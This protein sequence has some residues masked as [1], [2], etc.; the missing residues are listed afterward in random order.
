MAFVS[1][2]SQTYTYLNDI[3]LQ[4]QGQSLSLGLLLGLSFHT[5]PRSPVCVWGRGVARRPTS[6]RVRDR[7]PR[8]V[9]VSRASVRVL[10]LRVGVVGGLNP[11]TLIHSHD[12]SHDAPSPICDHFHQPKELQIYVW[13]YYPLVWYL[14]TRASHT[15]PF[16]TKKRFVLNKLLSQA[17][18][19]KRGP[20][21]TSLRHS[22]VPERRPGP[23]CDSDGEGERIVLYV[24]LRAAALYGPR[25]AR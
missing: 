13:L 9:R 23:D 11:L 21:H 6:R 8:H 22:R 4:A 14:P 10:L 5:S 15:P 17:K 16:A 25:L 24:L 18:K 1:C 7:P 2:P 19:L 12:H 20:P 3:C